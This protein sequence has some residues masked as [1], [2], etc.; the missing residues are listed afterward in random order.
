MRQK[1]NKESCQQK[2]TAKAAIKTG[3]CATDVVCN[4]GF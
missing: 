3:G 1:E 4:F 2:L